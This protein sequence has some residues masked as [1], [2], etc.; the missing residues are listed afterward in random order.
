M[1]IYSFILFLHIAAGFCALI[2]GCAAII[3]PKGKKVHIFAGQIYFWSMTAVAL[4]ALYLSVVNP[5]PFL[6]LISLFSF[7]LTWSGYKA[8]HWK[9]RPLKG[10]AAIFNKMLIPLFLLIGCLMVV[11]SLLDWISISISE[12][13]ARSNIL[14]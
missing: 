9:N 10:F 2:T 4:S 12:R 5:N 8:I 7:F 6:L 13:L 11:L 3:A 1:K 14:L